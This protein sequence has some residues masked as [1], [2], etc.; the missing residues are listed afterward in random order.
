MLRGFYFKSRQSRQPATHTAPAK[1]SVFHGNAYRGVF[2]AV[3]QRISHRLLLS[4]EEGAIHVLRAALHQQNLPPMSDQSDDRIAGR[5]IAY[6]VNGVPAADRLAYSLQPPEN[7]DADR[8]RA[9]RLSEQ[10]QHCFEDAVRVL[11]PDLRQ[12]VISRLRTAGSSSSLPCRT[13]SSHQI[14]PKQRDRRIEAMWKL[15]DEI[16]AICDDTTS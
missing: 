5:A 7:E 10:I 9:R 3:L 2:D 15:A 1:D 8:D 4:P 14:D 16:D 12:A 6:F 13:I 11:P